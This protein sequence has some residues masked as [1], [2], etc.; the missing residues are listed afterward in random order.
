MVLGFRNEGKREPFTQ[1]RVSRELV[2]LL[3]PWGTEGG[4]HLAFAMPRSELEAVFRRL[5]ECGIPFGDSFDAV[6]NLQGPQLERDEGGARGRGTSLY[7]FDPNQ[8]L[9]EIRH[10]E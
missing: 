1:L 4:Q 7:F 10:Y 8:H 9:I 2:L 3:G 5:R 6:G